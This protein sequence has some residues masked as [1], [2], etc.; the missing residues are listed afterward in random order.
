MVSQIRDPPEPYHQCFYPHGGWLPMG[1]RRATRQIC[2]GAGEWQGRKRPD[3]A[4][5]TRERLHLSDWHRL[6]LGCLSA[7]AAH[8]STHAHSHA[9][10]QVYD[11]VSKDLMLPLA[12]ASASNGELS[13]S[14]WHRVA[15]GCLSGAAAALAVYPME[16][17]RTNMTMGNRAL[18]YLGLAREI[19]RRA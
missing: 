11:T 13:L 2:L 6:A 4:A 1:E 15:A 9:D 14:N 5:G 17:L 18:G 19:V 7:A 10:L 3:A 12:R 8:D 16:T